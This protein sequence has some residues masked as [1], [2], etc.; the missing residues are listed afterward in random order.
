MDLVDPVAL[1]FPFK[2]IEPEYLNRLVTDSQ[3]YVVRVYL[4][5]A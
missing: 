1:E 5:S 2:M 3:T 4:I